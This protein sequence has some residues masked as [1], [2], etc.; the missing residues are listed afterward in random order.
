MALYEHIYLARQDVSQQQVEELTAQ[1]KG[2]IE[3]MGGKV[4]KTEQWGVKSLSY[5]LRKNRKAHFT[6]FN[7]EAPAAALGEIDTPLPK[8]ILLD[9]NPEG[10]EFKEYKASDLAGW[11]GPE[12][13]PVRLGSRYT[14]LGRAADS[15]SEDREERDALRRYFARRYENERRSRTAAAQNATFERVKGCRNNV[16]HKLHS[17]LGSEGLPAEFSQCFADMVA[18]L[19]KIEVWWI[20]N[21]EIPTNPDFDGVEVDESGIVPGPVMTMQLLMDIALGDDERSRF[22][23]DEFRKHT[24][25]G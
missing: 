14:Q 3:Q 24:A 4:G 16:A 5:R 11:L 23:Y 13:Q 20:T 22:Y 8:F 19:R 25:G 15:L 1:F 7:V 2:V 10:N 6:L 18:L 12:H 9:P 17:V 21:V